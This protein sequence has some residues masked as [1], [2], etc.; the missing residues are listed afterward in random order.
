MESS[1]IVAVLLIRTE[2]NGNRVEAESDP[3]H[4]LIVGSHIPQ[5]PTLVV[6]DT[7]RTA[8]FMSIFVPR[9]TTQMPHSRFFSK[10]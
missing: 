7:K 1:T 9:S 3:S 5:F 2:W 8:V 10:A 4:S 6:E